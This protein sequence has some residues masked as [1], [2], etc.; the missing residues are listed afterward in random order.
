MHDSLYYIFVVVDVSDKM[1]VYVRANVWW[2]SGYLT[3]VI[4]V[5]TA[6]TTCEIFH[7]YS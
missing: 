7:K 1:C 6:Q 5:Y 3:V 4:P 2:N